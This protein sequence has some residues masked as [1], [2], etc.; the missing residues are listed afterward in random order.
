[1]NKQIGV[2]RTVKP[3]IVLFVIIALAFYSKKDFDSVEK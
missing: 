1:M 3:F 2:I